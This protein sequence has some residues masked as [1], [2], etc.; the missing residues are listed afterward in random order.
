MRGRRGREGVGGR[1][2]EGKAVVGVRREE[3]EGG[4]GKMEIVATREREGRR[5]GN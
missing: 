3:G 2:E 5:G 4:E 1:R